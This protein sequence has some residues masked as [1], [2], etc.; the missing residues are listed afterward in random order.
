MNKNIIITAVG[1]IM[2]GR[3]IEEYIKKYKNNN[4]NNIFKY[5]KKYIEDSNISIGNLECLISNKT[6]DRLF[7]KKGPSFIAQPKSIDALINSGLNTINI[8]NNHSNDYGNEAMQDTI[9]ILKKNNFNI[10][11]K[12]DIPYKEYNIDNIKIIVLGISRPWNRLKNSNKVYIY[13][14]DT[15]RLIKNLKKKCDILIVTVHWGN[16]YIFNNNTLQKNMSEKMI[17]NGCDI[18]IGHHPHVL[19]NME[20]IKLNNR[21]GYIF[22]SLGNFVLDDPHNKKGVRDTMILKILI[23]KKTKQINFKYLPCIIYPELGFIPK[24]SNKIFQ[25]KFPDFYTDKAQKLDKTVKDYFID[26]NTPKGYKTRFWG[27]NLQHNYY[28]YS[29]IVLLFISIIL[30]YLLKI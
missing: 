1:D 26:N 22:Y 5:T 9:D 17:K 15:L 16:E 24:P 7:F 3:S 20:T 8:T 29:I 30:K 19:Q 4:Y 14:N 18:I 12:K 27:G 25:N 6:K 10:V 13:N 28:L 23:N 21:T 2:L 11:G